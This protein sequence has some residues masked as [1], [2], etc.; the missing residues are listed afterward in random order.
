MG[1]LVDESLQYVA[2]NLGDIIVLPIDMSCLSS[3]LVKRLAQKIDLEKLE[4]L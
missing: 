2:D 1:S 3:V 4:H